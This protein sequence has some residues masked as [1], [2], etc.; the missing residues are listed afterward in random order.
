MSDHDHQ[1]KRKH[2]AAEV[3]QTDSHESPDNNYK[4][5]YGRPPLERRYKPGC[6]GNPKGRPKGS[7][8]AKTIVSGVVNKKVPVRQNGKVRHVTTLEA[9]L[10]AAAQSALKGDLRALNTIIGLMARTNQLAEEETETSTALP[11]ED[12]AILNDF[13]RRQSAAADSDR[14]NQ[15]ENR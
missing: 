3:P 4:V 12:A 1:D 8:N 11:E 9:M 15:L 2:P 10:L 7:R 5:G 6:S 14:A 13:L